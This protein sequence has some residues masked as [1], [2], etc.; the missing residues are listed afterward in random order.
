MV[1]VIN[2]IDLVL[3]I[4]AWSDVLEHISCFWHL[5]QWTN[6]VPNLILSP[7][8]AFP[9][10]R[11]WRQI[12][13]KKLNEKQIPPFF[14]GVRTMINDKL[15]TVYC[16][17]EQMIRNWKPCLSKELHGEGAK[18]LLF[19]EI[20]QL[21]GRPMSVDAGLWTWIKIPAVIYS[22][23]LCSTSLKKFRRAVQQ[24]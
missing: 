4:S 13:E 11:V 7:S 10:K 20:C 3:M 19:L 14:N 8:P 23:F 15:V 18:T 22:R 12:L 9:A 5:F 21:W 17:E 2:I 6:L 16:E 24:T 1:C